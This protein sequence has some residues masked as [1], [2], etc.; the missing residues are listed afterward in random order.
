MASNE[1]HTEVTFHLKRD[2][3]LAVL[4]A[5]ARELDEE[6]DLAPETYTLPQMVQ[7]I[8]HQD[9]EWLHKNALIGWTLDRAADDEGAMQPI[10]P[11]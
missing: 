11:N 7:V 1:L 10:W 3:D 6:G 8:W 5:K 9:P 4:E 2:L